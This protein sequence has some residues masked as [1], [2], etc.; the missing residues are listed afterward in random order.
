LLHTT[1]N[2]AQERKMQM[3]ENP[4]VALAARQADKAARG[5]SALSAAH[6][7]LAADFLAAM[8]AGDGERRMLT[9][10]F[11][12]APCSKPTMTLA[13]LMY[14]DFDAGKASAAIRLLGACMRSRDVLLRME[15]NAIAADMAKAYADMHADASVC[16]ADDDGEVLA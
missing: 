15:A 3:M 9:P 4:A 10:A 7:T 8:E 1:R 2:D 14:D 11:A 5:A 16:P 6:R 13:A 12:D